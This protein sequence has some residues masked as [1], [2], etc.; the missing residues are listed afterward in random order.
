MTIN[1]SGEEDD[2]TVAR[3]VMAG[4][5]WAI[6]DADPEQSELLVAPVNDKASAPKWLGE[7][8][9]VPIEVGQGI[10]VLRRAIAEE[11]GLLEGKEELI[12]DLAADEIEILTGLKNQAIPEIKQYPV[13][14]EAMSILVEAVTSHIDSTGMLPCDNVITIERRDDALVL[15]SCFWYTNKRSN[16]SLFTCNG[17]YENWKMGKINNRFNTNRNPKF[18]P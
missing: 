1:D 6:V 14:D 7:S 17:V 2:G 4:R 13:D 3:F 12:S 8:P 16:R 5:T 9:P 10:G 11:F 15:N 18:R